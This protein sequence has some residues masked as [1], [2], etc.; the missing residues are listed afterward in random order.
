MAEETKPSFKHAVVKK[1]LAPIVTAITAYLMKKAA[2]LWQERVEPK[3]EEQGGAEAVA[4][5]AAET[6]SDKLAPVADTVASKVSHEPDAPSSAESEPAADNDRAEERRKR[7]QRRRQR[8][9]ALEQSG[10]S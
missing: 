10:S 8:R 5:Q 9:K 7:E 2:E 3:L 1:A 4:R 6:V